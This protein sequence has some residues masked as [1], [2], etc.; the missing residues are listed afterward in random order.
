MLSS[1]DNNVCSPKQ[2]AVSDAVSLVVLAGLLCL[3]NA[4]ITVM[5]HHPQ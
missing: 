5:C 2:P 3:M 1:R 4:R